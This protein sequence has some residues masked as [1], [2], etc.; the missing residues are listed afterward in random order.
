MLYQHFST[1]DLRV[2]D[3]MRRSQFFW[4]FLDGTEMSIR[5]A[6]GQTENIWTPIVGMDPT[7]FHIQGI[8]VAVIVNVPP[9]DDDQTVR[10]LKNRR[11]G[12]ETCTGWMTICL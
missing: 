2:I 4:W 12:E 9:A 5:R 1:S 6:N 7:F 3:L 8:S 10:V 11:T